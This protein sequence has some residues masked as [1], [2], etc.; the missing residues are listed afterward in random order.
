VETWKELEALM[1]S[2]LERAFRGRVVEFDLK[3]L[4]NCSD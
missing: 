4:E 3:I 1:A 2:I